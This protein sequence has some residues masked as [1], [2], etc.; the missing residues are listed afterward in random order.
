MC[1][2]EGAARVGGHHRETQT[3]TRGQLRRQRQRDLMA[4]VAE[5]AEGEGPDIFGLDDSLCA[6]AEQRG[7]ERQQERQRERQ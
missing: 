7:L 4:E 2:E 1:R 6:T 5:G 3:D